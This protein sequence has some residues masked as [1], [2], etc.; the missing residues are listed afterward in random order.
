M[1]TAF[2]ERCVTHS[3]GCFAMHEASAIARSSSR[4]R[5]RSASSF[6]LRPGPATLIQEAFSTTS[7]AG[8]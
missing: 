2:S 4:P 5:H 6:A 7:T 1:Y 3:T 8:W